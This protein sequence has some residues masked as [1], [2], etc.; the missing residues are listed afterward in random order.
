[1][2]IPTSRLAYLNKIQDGLVFFEGFENDNFINAEGWNTNQGVAQN[3]SNQ[4]LPQSNGIKS[5]QCNGTGATLCNIIKPITNQTPGML[6]QAWLY[7]DG[8]TTGK[9]PYV[10]LKTNLGNFIQFGIR[11]N[12]STTDY[13]FNAN[14]VFTEDNFSTNSGRYPRSVGWHCISISSDTGTIV[15]W[16]DSGVNTTIGTISIN[17]YITSIYVCS[18]TLSDTGAAFGYFDNI[19]LFMGTTVDFVGPSTVSPYE[20][21]LVFGTLG[22]TVVLDTG[23]TING[24]GRVQKLNQAFPLLNV[25]L[26]IQQPSTSLALDVNNAESAFIR[27]INPGDIFSYNVIDFG[28][29]AKP[30]NPAEASLINQNQS[31]SGI[32]ETLFHAYKDTYSIGFNVLEGLTLKKQL[33]NFYR[34]CSQGFQFSFLMSTAFNALG[35]IQSAVVGSQTI[36]MNNFSGDWPATQFVAGRKYRAFNIE[37]TLKQTFTVNSVSDPNLSTLEFVEYPFQPGDMVVEET[38]YPFLELGSNPDGFQMTDERYVRFNWIQGCQD[39][40]GI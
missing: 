1:M 25:L 10:K 21:Q 8:T 3:S 6:F 34:Y 38:F 39:Y 24:G 9:G 22:T 12:V 35:I 33:N 4:Y 20:Y 30:F 15:V 31:S 32:M 29:K 17:D 18:G 16:L 23:T 28:R 27:D 37:N 26:T 13:S 40:N 5:F 7:D 11:N 2:G 19:G 36:T 14:G